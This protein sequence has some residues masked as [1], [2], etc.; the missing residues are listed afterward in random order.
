MTHESQTKHRYIKYSK[1]FNTYIGQVQILPNGSGRHAQKGMTLLVG[2]ILLVMLTLI[3]I[4]GFRNT[5]MSERMTGNSVDRNTSFQSAENAGKEAFGVIEA[6][7]FNPTTAGHY[8]SALSNGGESDFWVH[9]AGTAL[10]TP[11][12]ECLTSTPF[13]WISCSVAIGTKYVNNAAKAQYVIELIAQTSSGGST[14][15]DYRITSR[16]TGG[17]GNAEVILQS[18]Y[19]RKTT[20]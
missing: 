13:R 6:G 11:A 16:S 3:G 8:G 14:V 5:T 18:F 20:P 7:T 12:T 10:S 17:S 15:F 19:S 9:G 1:V 4:I 2:M